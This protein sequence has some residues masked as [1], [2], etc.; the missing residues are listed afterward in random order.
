MNIVDLD[1]TIRSEDGRYH[2]ALAMM[3]AKAA[4]ENKAC[5]ETIVKDRWKM[6]FL[7]SFDFWNVHHVNC[8]F[9]AIT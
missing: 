1:E 9:T 4:Y 8:R 3:A 7:G 5:I 6:D 2:P